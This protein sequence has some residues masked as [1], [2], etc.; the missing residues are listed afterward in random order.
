MRKKVGKTNF[1]KFRLKGVI[2][3]SRSRDDDGGWITFDNGPVD[4]VGSVRSKAKRRS[5]LIRGLALVCISISIPIGMKW[6][7]GKVFFENEEFL[8]NRLNIQSDGSLSELKL[9]VIANVSAGMN[10]MELDLAAIEQQIGQLP[11][12]EKVSVTR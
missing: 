8:L 12:V 3:S 11:Q 4:P 9:A 2:S 5:L 7:Y 6:G 1:R 10:L